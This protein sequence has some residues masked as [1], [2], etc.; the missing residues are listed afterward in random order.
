MNGE[1]NGPVTWKEESN[2]NVDN[3]QGINS[4]L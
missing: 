3:I 2:S 1:G 4:E